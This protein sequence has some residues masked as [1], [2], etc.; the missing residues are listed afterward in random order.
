MPDKTLLQSLKQDLLRAMVILGAMTPPETLT[1]PSPNFRAGRNG[2][3]PIAI[4]IHRSEGTAASCISWFS[5][6]NSAVSA[7]YMVKLDGSLISFVHDYDTAWHAGV[8]RNPS[9]ALYNP[10]VNP[11]Q[12]TIGIETEGNLNDV[13]QFTQLHA[14][15]R[16]V[17]Q[18]AAKWSIPL[19]A[20]HIIGHNA[21]NSV[22]RADCPSSDK[23]I[24]PQ[25]IALATQLSVADSHVAGN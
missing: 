2:H 13:W 17:A 15:A 12:V 24:V 18:L 6:P 5:D 7:H 8:V 22:T 10:Q 14:V 1:N 19:D 4:V 16:L 25:I 20:N 21:I 11:N 9:W 23:T 3:V